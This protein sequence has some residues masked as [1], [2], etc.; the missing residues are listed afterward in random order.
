MGHAVL[1]PLMALL[2]IAFLNFP[3]TLFAD[4][5]RSKPTQE[6]QFVGS[7]ALL[8]LSFITLLLVEAVR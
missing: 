7:P 5:E 3:F 1:L 8:V 2:S 6:P 4:V